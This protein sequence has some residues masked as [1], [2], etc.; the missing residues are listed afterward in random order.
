[1]SLAAM[2][3]LA[4]H[5][6]SMNPLLVSF[7]YKHVSIANSIVIKPSMSVYLS[8]LGA[9]PHKSFLNLLFTCS[10]GLKRMYAVVH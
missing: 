5:S 8:H 3:S 10:D 9:Q 6:D 4:S 1:M 7:I 2:L